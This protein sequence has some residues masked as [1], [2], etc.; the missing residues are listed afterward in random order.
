M[1]RC[2]SPFQL[3]TLFAVMTICFFGVVA[4]ADDQ[5]PSS[6]NA[7]LDRV[8][9]KGLNYLATKGQAEGGTFSRRAG[10]GLTALAI[11]A[12]LRNGK[13]VDD[14]MV[15]KGLRALEGF[16]KP[17]GGIYGDGRIRSYETC[18]GI[19]CFAEANKSGT[20]TAILKNARAFL[21]SLQNG[22]AKDAS[23]DDPTFGGYGYDGAGRPDLSNTAYVLEAL[24]ALDVEASDPAVQRALVFISRC[25]NLKSPHNDLPLAAKVNDGGFFYTLPT[26]EELE[27]AK[28][29]GSEGGLRSYGSMT[30]S[31]L[32]SMIYAG[33]NEDDIRVK[34]ALV[35]IGKN[36]LLDSNPG[37]GSAGLFYYFHTFATTMKAAKVDTFTDSEGKRHDWRAELIAELAKRQNEDGSWT[38]ANQRWLENDENLSTSFALMALSYCR[39]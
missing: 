9:A 32:K 18:I 3:R 24:H 16:V 19:L 14:P 8:V 36:Y 4:S 39:K 20:Y 23:A 38:N 22:T 7:E 29:D 30:Y 26:E 33:L 35:W 25:Q 15:A 5:T 21:I 17:D 12:A 11:T 31:G 2:L 1:A 13:T 37:L 28:G 34:S 6:A 10:P 27:S